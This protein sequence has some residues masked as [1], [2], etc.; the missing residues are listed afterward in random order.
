MP[1][2]TGDGGVDFWLKSLFPELEAQ[3]VELLL[4]DLGRRSGQKTKRARR[5]GERDDLADGFF[6]GQEHDDAVEPH[7]DPAVRR[8]PVAERLQEIPE[9]VLG[10]FL[11]AAQGTEDPTLELK[12]VDPDGSAADF[13]S[14]ADN[15]IRSGPC[16]ER[17]SFEERDVLDERGREGMMDKDDLL[18][19]LTP[20]E[21]GKIGHPGEGA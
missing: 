11:R 18:F 17:L 19:L 10:L 5:L 16:P 3:L 15:V 21:E 9:F 13:V 14:I 2:P 6:S 1:W 12:V 8:R 20:F 7:G 4:A